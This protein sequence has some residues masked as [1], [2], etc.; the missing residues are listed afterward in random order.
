MQS[1]SLLVFIKFPDAPRFVTKPSNVAANQGDSVT[2]NCQVDANPKPVYSWNKI[3]FD[4]K[5]S[6]E[7]IQVNFLKWQPWQ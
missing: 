1:V 4:I 6:E 7:K 5:G 3:L 2:L